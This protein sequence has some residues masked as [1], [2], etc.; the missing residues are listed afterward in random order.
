MFHFCFDLVCV[1]VSQNLLSLGI[2]LFW[3]L[4][5]FTAKLW[6]L[7][8]DFSY[9]TVLRYSDNFACLHLFSFLF[10]VRCD[11]YVHQCLY[12]IV[13]SLSLSEHVHRFLFCLD[14]KASVFHFSPERVS[15]EMNSN[16]SP[17]LYFIPPSFCTSLT[18]PSVCAVP[19]SLFR[20]LWT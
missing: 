1:S 7:S 8:Q 11:L 12:S 9:L 15:G 18:P 2:C 20:E 14:E 10:L 6:L 4:S 17:A 3:I 13:Q 16:V 5:L 19:G